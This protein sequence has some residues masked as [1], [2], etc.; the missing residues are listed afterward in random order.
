[1]GL[2]CRVLPYHIR[3]GDEK[4]PQGSLRARNR[5]LIREWEV[6][7]GLRGD[8]IL[9]EFKRRRWKVVSCGHGDLVFKDKDSWLD[10][11]E[12]EPSTSEDTPWRPMH[13]KSVSAKTV[14]W[15][16]GEAIVISGVVLPLELHSK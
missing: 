4:G 1:M 9:L 3:A 12:F 13:V 7:F 16:F 5:D 11:H 15:K 10:C 8:P 14:G 6:K 2:P